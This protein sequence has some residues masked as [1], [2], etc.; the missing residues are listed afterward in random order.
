MNLSVESKKE[1]DGR[2][3]NDMQPPPKGRGQGDLALSIDFCPEYRH[4]I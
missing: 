2:S 3:F 1:L 4:L